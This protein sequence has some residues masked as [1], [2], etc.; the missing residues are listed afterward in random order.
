[1]QPFSCKKRERTKK[2]PGLIK[3]REVHRNYSADGAGISSGMNRP[4][5]TERAMNA[6]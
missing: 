4:P 1:M 6:S 5:C 2:S 3:S